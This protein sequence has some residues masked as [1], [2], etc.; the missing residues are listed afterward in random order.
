MY[1]DIFNTNGS[2]RIKKINKREKPNLNYTLKFLKKYSI[3]YSILQ[4]VC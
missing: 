4:N 1:F 3:S 2:V